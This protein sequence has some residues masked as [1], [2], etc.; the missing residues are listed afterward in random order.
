MPVHLKVLLSDAAPKPRWVSRYIHY[1]L[2]EFWVNV[3]DDRVQLWMFHVQCFIMKLK[4]DVNGPCCIPLA[5]ASRPHVAH[6]DTS[7]TARTPRAP[8]CPDRFAEPFGQWL[9]KTALRLDSLETLPQ[10]S[11]I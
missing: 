8:L 1:A 9:H 7:L 11:L 10:G 2:A 5:P 4:P 3:P 6:G